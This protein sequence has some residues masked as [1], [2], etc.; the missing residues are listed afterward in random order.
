M[1]LEEKHGVV[2]GAAYRNDT[3][4]GVIVDF[5]ADSFKSDLKKELDR[6]N[7]YSILT[8][9]STDASTTEKEAMFVVTFD[10]KPPNSN[11]IKINSSYLDVADL[12]GSR[13]TW[14][15]WSNRELISNHKLW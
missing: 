9:G 5:I 15:N 14:N 4:A 6:I 7:F 2:I 1:K 11:K 3:S 10:P 12:N 13:C 8:D